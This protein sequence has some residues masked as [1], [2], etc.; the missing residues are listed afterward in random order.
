[1]LS[2]LSLKRLSLRQSIPD[3]LD[4][5]RT[6]DELVVIGGVLGLDVGEIEDV[7]LLRREL[8]PVG[9][10]LGIDGAEPRVAAPY[11]AG[12]RERLVVPRSKEREFR[13]RIAHVRDLVFEHVDVHVRRRQHHVVDLRRDAAVA[14]RHL[15]Q[16]LD[17]EPIAHRMGE[18]VDLPH[19]GIA[20]EHVEQLLERVARQ[21]RAFPVITISEHAAARWPG[22]ED[23]RHLGVGIV[24]ELRGAEDGVAQAGV[25]A[26]HEDKRAVLA[27]RGAAEVEPGARRLEVEAA[28]AD[29]DKVGRWISRRRLRPL[30][31][32]G[33]A[34]A[35]RRNRHDD[36]GEAQARRH[37]RPN[38]VHRD[39]QRR[40]A[41]RPRACRRRKRPG[42][43]PRLAR[44]GSQAFR[45]KMQLR[46]RPSEGTR[47]ASPW[48]R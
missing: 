13:M 9:L 44:T 35:V 7:H 40:A 47:C 10:G 37:A 2:W 22:E 18:N 39:L 16:R 28:H 26:V 21:V 1:M 12:E 48:G 23:W 24:D 29:R 3:K 27:R 5:F 6:V 46:T 8:A 38:K 4:Q 36:I 20:D 41:S 25:V 14:D 19:G 33:G 32:A 11:P 15:P 45:R 30:D 17:D 34:R 43:S 42:R 31:L